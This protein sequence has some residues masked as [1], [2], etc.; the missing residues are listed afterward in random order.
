[1]TDSKRY[2][3]VLNANFSLSDIGAATIRFTPSQAKENWFRSFKYFNDIGFLYMPC[4]P[5]HVAEIFGDVDDTTWFISTLLE[6]SDIVDYNTPLKSKL[7]KSK[8][9]TYINY[10]LR[11]NATKISKINRPWSKSN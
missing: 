3:G 6:I 8:L 4:V 2:S 1:M 10:W 5:F 7:I 11:Q 9:V